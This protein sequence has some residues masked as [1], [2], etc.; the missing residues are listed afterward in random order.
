MNVYSN[1]T[2][3][4]IRFLE[5]HMFQT[6]GFKLYVLALDCG[7]FPFYIFY[8]TRSKKPTELREYPQS[9]TAPFPVL[10]PPFVKSQ[11][12]IC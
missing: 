1:I 5:Q 12:L 9:K 6:L 7:G 8:I 2:K 10:R 11:Y 4:L 3:I